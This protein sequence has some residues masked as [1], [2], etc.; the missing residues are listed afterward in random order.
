M[1]RDR[2]RPGPAAAAQHGE[3]HPPAQ[4]G[5]GPAGGEGE[6]GLD[7]GPGNQLM[8]CVHVCMCLL[9]VCVCVWEGGGH[10]L[11][12][13]VHLCACV[14]VCD[15]GRWGGWVWVCIRVCECMCVECM[16]RGAWVWVCIHAYVHHFVCEHA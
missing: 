4:A 14:C 2:G 1:W 12:L 16:G 13:C 9:H 7:G 6:H 8:L 11:L 5:P 10:Q 3:R 15:Y